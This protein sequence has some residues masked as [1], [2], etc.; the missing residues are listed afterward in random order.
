MFSPPM[1]NKFNQIFGDRSKPENKVA[2]MSKATSAKVTDNRIGAGSGD[3]QA[4]D[5]WE[6]RR[7]KRANH[8]YQMKSTEGFDE[9]K[10][11]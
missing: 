4:K 5:G 2:S 7:M 10:G 6:Y 8:G 1:E 11:L 9:A 3:A